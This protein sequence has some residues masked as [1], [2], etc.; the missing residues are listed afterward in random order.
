MTTINIHTTPK[1][2]S[3][4]PRCTIAYQT[5]SSGEPS[6]LVSKLSLVFHP[7]FAC[8]LFPWLKCLL[9]LV[10]FQSL[11]LLFGIQ[12]TNTLSHQIALFLSVIIWKLALSSLFILPT[13]PKFPL[14]P[15]MCWWILHRT[16][17]MRFHNP[18]TRCAT[19]L[20]SF[21]RY[22]GLLLLLFLVLIVIRT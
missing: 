3:L 11:S 12:S 4:A 7:V 5:L 17:I 20:D 16:L 18:C 15:I 19:E 1:I 21:R 22:T 2:T 6:Y 14:F 8:Y 10:L 9:A 13:F